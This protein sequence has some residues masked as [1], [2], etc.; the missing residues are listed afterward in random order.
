[1]PR[2]PGSDFDTAGRRMRTRDGH[3]RPL[4]RLTLAPSGL[5]CALTFAGNPH[6]SYYEC[7]LLPGP[8]WVVSRFS[9]YSQLP[10]RHDWYIEP[11]LI[12][13]DA[14]VWRQRD[15]YLD[16]EVYEGDHYE[17]VDADEFADGL[18]AGEIS[19]HEAVAALRTLQQLCAALHRN[20]FSG[21]ALL[22]EFAPD[23]PR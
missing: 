15:L 8:G 18:A 17:L 11:D 1:M 3:W 5:Y 9:W 10:P 4:D 6:F 20:G 12:E 22:E 2:N 16:L 14:P 19:S 23:L 21:R 13:I 7:W